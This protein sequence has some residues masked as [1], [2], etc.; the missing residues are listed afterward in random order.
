[1]PRVPKE[2]NVVLTTAPLLANFD[3]P[4][5]NGP[6]SNEY[7]RTLNDVIQ[8]SSDSELQLSSLSQH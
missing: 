5:C 1:M 7:N 2:V 3:V 4:M 6:V 8:L